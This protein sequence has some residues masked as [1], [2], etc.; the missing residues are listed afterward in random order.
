MGYSLAG[1]HAGFAAEKVALIMDIIAGRSRP[2]EAHRLQNLAA[3]R[4]Q[5]GSDS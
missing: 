5:S 2:C 1:K 3:M 4:M